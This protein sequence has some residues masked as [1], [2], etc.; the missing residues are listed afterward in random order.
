MIW[1]ITSWHALATCAV[2][3]SKRRPEWLKTH[4]RGQS[5][6]QILKELQ[7]TPL[8]GQKSLHSLEAVSNKSEMQPP[9]STTLGYMK[10]CHMAHV[11]TGLWEDTSLVSME[12]KR[13]QWVGITAQLGI[14]S[15]AKT[16]LLVDRSS[17]MT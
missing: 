4:L 17:E 11:A 16:E 13:Q 10:P 5:E 9:A 7:T 2:G 6:S 12:H 15:V 3:T 14:S 1:A 8:L